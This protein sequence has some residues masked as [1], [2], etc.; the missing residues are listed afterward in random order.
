MGGKT[1]VGQTM[2][3]QSLTQVLD[4]KS[5]D[6]SLQTVLDTIKYWGKHYSLMFP[7]VSKRQTA[8]KALTFGP[9]AIRVKRLIALRQTYSIL[10]KL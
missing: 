10:N 7:G 3:D 4:S 9:D 6:D 8:P 1:V 5:F 2:T